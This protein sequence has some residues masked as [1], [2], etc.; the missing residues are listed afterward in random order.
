MKTSVKINRKRKVLAYQQCS[1]N[2]GKG[3]RTV[4]YEQKFM[5][6]YFYEV[7]GLKGCSAWSQLYECGNKS[8]YRN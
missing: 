4:V 7:D 5:Q 2:P 8:K 1:T 6:V 3:E